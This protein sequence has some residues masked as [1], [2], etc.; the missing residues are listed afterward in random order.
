MSQ[1]HVATYL[2]DH[3]AGSVVAL[4]LLE[5]LAKAHDGTPVG[6]FVVELKADIEQDRDELQ[7]LI[8][9][10]GAKASLPRRVAAWVS[11]KATEWKLRLDDAAGGELRLLEAMELVAVG[12]EGKRALWRALSAASS[13]NPSLRGPDYSRLEARADE[14][15]RRV[16]KVR[17]EAAT[18]ALKA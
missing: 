2:N 1:S 5:H 8:D 18:E 7:A 11:E 3:L 13:A 14:Q 6:W 16:E 10:V 15:R 12:I 4:E 9:K 17:L